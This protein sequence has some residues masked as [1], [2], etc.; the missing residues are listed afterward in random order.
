MVRSILFAPAD[1]PAM[2][3]KSL[4]AGADAVI[5]DLEDAVAPS[6]KD[7]A[8]AAIGEALSAL[9]GP[10]VPIVVRINA[11][12]ANTLTDDLERVVT[13]GLHAVLLPKVESASEIERLDR[14]LTRRERAAGL[15]EGAIGIHCLIES[16]LGILNAHAVASASRRVQALCFGA[17]DF[18]L[19]LGVPRTRDGVESAHA[20]AAMA[21]AAGAAKVLAIDTVYADLADSDGLVQECR[22]ARGLGFSGK[23]A[24]HP[25]QIETIN[26]EFSPSAAELAYAERVV[27]AFARAEAE[28]VGVITIDGKMID[29]P[30]VARARLILRTYTYKNN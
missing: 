12:G 28:G 5:W 29:A 1:K 21:L 8:R 9:S 15:A 17:E 27:Q 18:T 13:A 11:L 30:V 20:R 26:R 4:D 3:R 25:K 6:G 7:A 16:C 2:L 22:A 14:E 24:V 10:H 19:D 23:M